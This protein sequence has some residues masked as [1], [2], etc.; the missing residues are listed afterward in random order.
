MLGAPGDVLAAV[1]GAILD[2]SS[3]IVLV[4]PVHCEWSSL[5]LGA[6]HLRSVRIAI[7]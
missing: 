4:L 1:F 3:G 2:V 6:T 5:K 7:D